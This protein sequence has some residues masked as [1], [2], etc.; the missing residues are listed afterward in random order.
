MIPLDGDLKIPDLVCKK[1]GVALVVDVTVRYEMGPETLQRM[2]AEKVAQYSPLKKLIGM[3]V[4][5]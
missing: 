1:D 4:G 2:A 3:V 5:A